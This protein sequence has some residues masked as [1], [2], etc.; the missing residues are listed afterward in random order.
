MPP[1]L[2]NGRKAGRQRAEFE[3]I[4]IDGVQFTKD[5]CKHCG[6]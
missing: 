3:S 1:V 6:K 2:G 4:F 5:K